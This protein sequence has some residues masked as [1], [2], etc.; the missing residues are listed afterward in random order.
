MSYDLLHPGYVANRYYAG[1][2]AFT[3]TTTALPAINTIYFAPVLIVVPLRFD[4]VKVNVTTGVASALLKHALYNAD[5]ATKRPIGA[6]IAVNNT[7]LDCATSATTPEFTVDPAI[8]LT[9]GLYWFGC[10][11]S[12]QPQFQ[13]IANTASWASWDLGRSSGNSTAH[14]CGLFMSHTMALDMPTI[15]LGDT[16]SD[17]PSSGIPLP[18]FRAA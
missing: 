9:P 10:K 11:S 3:A 16:I 12:H 5:Q 4:R 15:A 8:S 1:Y 17:Q 6:P 2:P 18:W 13:S 14:M 7:G